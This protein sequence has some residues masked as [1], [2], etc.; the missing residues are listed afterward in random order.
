MI[1]NTEVENLM[2]KLFKRDIYILFSISTNI[3]FDQ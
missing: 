3:Y 1:Y 2:D